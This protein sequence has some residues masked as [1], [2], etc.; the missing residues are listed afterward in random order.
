[1]YFN[2]A[3]LIEPVNMTNYGV[4]ARVPDNS[5]LSL[6][7]SPIVS[8]GVYKLSH[9]GTSQ[10]LEVSGNSNQ[11]G[12][13]V[14]QNNDSGNDEQRWIITQESDGFYKLTH[15]GTTL[16]LD[17]AGT[18]AQQGTDLGNDAQHWRLESMTGG[19]FKIT[20]KGTSQSLTVD[21]NSPTALANVI[22]STD[23]GNDGQR[24]KLELVDVPIVTGGLYKLTHK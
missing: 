15:K 13:N 11:P 18:N 16:C 17:V 24:W 10:Y 8:G 9:K 4:K 22:Q 7:V 2:A 14:Q 5:C 12:A 1:M 23:N 19:Y 3:G 21:Q 6:P 20:N